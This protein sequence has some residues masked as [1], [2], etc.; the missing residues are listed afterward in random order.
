MVSPCSASLYAFTRYHSCRTSYRSNPINRLCI[1]W[2]HL[3]KPYLGYR[4]ISNY[5][6]YF[7]G[8]SLNSYSDYIT[9]VLARHFNRN[10]AS[11]YLNLDQ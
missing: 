6:I 11:S 7:S 9:C 3:R 5:I 10:F 4:P 8:S 2:I 1:Y